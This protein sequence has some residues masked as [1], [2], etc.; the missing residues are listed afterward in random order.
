VKQA[1]QICCLSIA[2]QY[3]DVS[4]Q[5]KGINVDTRDMAATFRS[6]GS[7]QSHHG[8]EDLVLLC[9]YE[10]KLPLHRINLVCE[11]PAAT[12]NRWAC[13]SDYCCFDK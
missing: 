2:K 6:I 9:S 7:L 11:L 8:V 4:L 5:H 10:L 13:N 12:L 1:P 3:I